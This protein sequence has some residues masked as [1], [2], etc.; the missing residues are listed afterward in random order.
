MS[1]APETLNVVWNKRPSAFH[2]FT[3]SESCHENYT[4]FVTKREHPF[5]LTLSFAWCIFQLRVQ[6][7]KPPF[8]NHLRALLRRLTIAMNGHL[9]LLFV[10]YL[11]RRADACPGIYASGF[12]HTTDSRRDSG[13]CGLLPFRR[14]TAFCVPFHEQW[15]C[16]E[17]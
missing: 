16:R 12:L 4:I 10:V 2:I 11:H 13:M 17:T 1:V 6:T 9:H 14:D 15:L 8:T 7:H 3:L 5:P